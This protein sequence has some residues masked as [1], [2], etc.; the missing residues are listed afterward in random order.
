MFI[1]LPNLT[2]TVCNVVISCPFRIDV[3]VCLNHQ[4]VGLPA[5]LDT[6]SSEINSLWQKELFN[7]QDSSSHDAELYHVVGVDHELPSHYLLS[8]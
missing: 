5:F 1:N 3:N 6:E 2:S 4:T 7:N 8:I